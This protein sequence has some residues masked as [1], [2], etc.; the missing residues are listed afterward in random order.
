MKQSLSMG[1]IAALTFSLLVAANC[2]C[3]EVVHGATNVGGVLYDN[4]TWTLANSPYI[5]TSTVKVPSNVTLTIEAGT[6][7]ISNVDLSH[8]TGD[9]FEIIG[10]II[11]HGT[12]DKKITFDGSNSST[13]FSAHTSDLN[14]FLDLDYC[15]IRNGRSLWWWGARLTSV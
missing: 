8:M 13:I 1:L 9:M 10:T 7:I 3:F 12:V 15:I 5:V 4:T 11:A 14:T 6:T 2:A